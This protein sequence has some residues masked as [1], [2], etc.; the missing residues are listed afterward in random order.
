ML[1]LLLL[2]LLL[3]RSSIVLCVGGYCSTLRLCHLVLRSV[4]CLLVCWI[5]HGGMHCFSVPDALQAT[6]C[7]IASSD[8][9]HDSMCFVMQTG[10]HTLLRCVVQHQG[11]DQR[12]AVILSTKWRATRITRQQHHCAFAIV[13]DGDI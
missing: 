5:N 7:S 1:L 3:S 6:V 11:L 4:D 12:V 13:V 10:L 8:H 2:L 9:G